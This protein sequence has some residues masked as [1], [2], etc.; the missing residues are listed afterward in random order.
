[1]RSPK[2]VNRD[3]MAQNIDVFDFQLTREEMARIVDLH[4]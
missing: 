4:R 1:V 2:W 3:R